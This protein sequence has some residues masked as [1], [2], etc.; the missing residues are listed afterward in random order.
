MVPS[1]DSAMRLF[2]SFLDRRFVIGGVV[3]LLALSIATG[4][5][6]A[7]GVAV[8]VIC[9]LA[10]LLLPDPVGPVF[11]ALGIGLALY[12]FGSVRRPRP[13]P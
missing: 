6:L 5:A 13:T 12:V 2:V 10:G 1:Q 4:T 8:G 7:V 11:I 9:I 3:V